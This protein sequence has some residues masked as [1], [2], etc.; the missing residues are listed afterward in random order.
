LAKQK[1]KSPISI[2]AEIGKI[3]G[4]QDFYLAG[5]TALTLLIGHRGS[6][7]LDFFREAPFKNQDLIASLRDHFNL[8][9]QEDQEKTLHVSLDGIRVSFLEYPYPLLGTTEWRGVRL[10]SIIDI[11]LMKII[12]IHQRGEKK[13]FIDLYWILK[14]EKKT[15]WDIF[16]LFEKKFNRVSYDWMSFYK[17][18]V[19]FKDANKSGPLLMEKENW[20]EVKIFFKKEVKKLIRLK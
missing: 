16:S 7:D 3:K 2:L 14:K 6:L 9:I 10:A 12:G 11:A 4:V 1:T 8:K 13:D 18:L 19:F 20:D 15:L 17:S 5:G